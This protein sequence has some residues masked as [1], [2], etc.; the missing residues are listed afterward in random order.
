MQ[1]PRWIRVTLRLAV[2][3]VLLVAASVQAQQL[4]LPDDDVP[5]TLVA[6]RID[7]DNEAGTVTAVGNVE[8]YYGE[9]TLT[10]DKIVYDNQTGRIRAEG[11]IV[12]R[13]PVGATVFADAAELDADL[14][15]GL[16][17]GARTVFSEHVRIAAVEGQRVGGRYNALSKAVYSACR[18]CE[19]DPTPLWRIRAR[20]IVHDEQE[21]VIHYESAT[22]DLM[23]V[24]VAWFPYFSHPDPTV[25]RATGLLL[26]EFRQ[27]SIYGYGVKQPFFWAI[28]PS[29]DL[30]VTPFLTTGDGLLME[31]IYRQA[32]DTGDLQ[33][34][35]SI[36]WNDYD[37]TERVRGHVDTHGRFDL[38]GEAFWGWDVQFTS[39]DG[40]PE[41]FDYALE[42]RLTSTLYF[43]KYVEDGFIDVSAV[44]FQSLRDDEPA[45]QIPTALPVFEV[46]QNYQ[47]P[48]LGG[49]I[50][51][52]SSGQALFRNNGEDSARLSAGGEWERHAVLPV[53]LALEAF[54][55][56][57]IDAFLA[58][59]DLTDNPE[60]TVRITGTGGIEARYPLIAQSSNGWQHIIEPL[61]QFALSP[62]GGNPD[63]IPVEDSIVTEFDETNILDR[64]HFPGY[65]RVEEGA[66][67][68]L[69]L[70][71]EVLATDA[72][73]FDA[74]VGRVFRVDDALEFSSGSGLATAQ[75]D[76]VAAWQGRFAPYLNVSHRM[77]FSDEGK[78]TRNEFVGAFDLAD[79]APVTFDVGYSFY[80]A[81]PD[82]GAPDAREELVFATT[83]RLDRNWRMTADMQRDL[84]ADSFVRVGG[85]IGYE[86]ECCALDLYVNRRFTDTDDIPEETSFGLRVKLLT[87]GDGARE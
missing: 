16:V 5:V 65:D 69:A 73:S 39:D 83:A 34:G 24:P 63:S 14:T 54:G 80:D 49:R 23:G 47:D 43:E 85:T 21:R 3:A 9:R 56:A 12:V 11:E 19:D 70:R 36:A 20:R 79:V 29:R 30:T 22:F 8:V 61:A 67:V 64:S 66:R 35:G 2:A 28:D 13:D 74:T 71:Y 33:F 77:R 75:S 27:S 48:F 53:G 81:D 76:Y 45:G 46:H 58:A 68:N 38:G 37:G 41:L 1:A 52:F 57:R 17:Q 84:E 51:L 6:D 31:G 25:K 40:Y 72:F 62:F 59:E 26:P 4:S 87:L 32:F 7:F 78:V 44:R 55:D 82:V 50:G 60:A 10:A 18:V 86:N 42:D 15:E